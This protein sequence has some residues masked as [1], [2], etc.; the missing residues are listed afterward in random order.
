MINWLKSTQNKLTDFNV[1]SVARTLVEAPA[2]EVDELYQQ[3]FNGLKEGIEVSVYNSFQFAALPATPATGLIRVFITA[4]VSPVFI[5][6]GTV[7]SSP[8]T[9]SQYASI[10]DATI[11]VA[12]TF[13]DVSV[14]ATTSGASG[15]LV[16]GASFTLIPVP[17]GF[18]IA[19]N[20]SAFVSGSD[21]ETNDERKIRFNTFIQ[22]LP[23]GTLSAIKYG[24]STTVLYD[25]FGNISERVAS[26][27][28]VEPYL[29]DSMQPI[30][31]VKCY[32]HNG[33]GSTTGALVAQAAKVVLGYDDDN[34]VAVPGWSAAGVKVEVF[35][36][37]ETSV[38]I[39]GSLTAINGFDEPTL[40]T[41]ATQAVYAYI[42]S[43]GIGESVIL[44]ELIRL[45]KDIDGVYDITFSLPLAN[46]TA[47]A[48]TKLVHGTILIT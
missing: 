5:P 22:S 3:M 27:S 36:A 43:R 8:A 2:A 10:N 38:S 13:I 31:W 30:A 33:V 48:Q 1:G 26:S 46:V 16:S 34:G 45:V 44:A 37:T 15:N 24:L 21:A 23:R 14:A 32:I 6:A 40:I 35:A 29:A 17:I 47:D 39:T 28:L 42:A 20:V 25:A 4:Q 7:F 12:G 9:A 18:S 11:P 19:S 41:A